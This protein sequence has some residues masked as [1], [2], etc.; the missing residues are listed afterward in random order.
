MTKAWR[1]Q[2]LEIHA[3]WDFE[4]DIVSEFESIVAL[5]SSRKEEW[6]VQDGRILF[7]NEADL[8][9][10]DRHLASIEELTGKEEAIGEQSAE[11]I[12][13]SLDRLKN[14]IHSGAWTGTAR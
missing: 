1:N 5:L 11:A 12:N 7:S 4:A 13:G 3:M 14:N 2:D 6:V 8:K 9:A 10:Y